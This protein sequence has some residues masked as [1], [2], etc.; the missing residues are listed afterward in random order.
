MRD[1]EGRLTKPALW[2]YPS[3]GGQVAETDSQTK[4]MDLGR[5]GGKMGERES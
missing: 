1:E 5:P 2:G 3:S 4:K